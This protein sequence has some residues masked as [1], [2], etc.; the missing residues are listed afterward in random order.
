ML[1]LLHTLVLVLALNAQLY[2][3]CTR[4]QVNFCFL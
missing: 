4:L 2:L 3:N 1:M